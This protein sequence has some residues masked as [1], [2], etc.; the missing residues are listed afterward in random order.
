MAKARLA[1]MTVQNLQFIFKKITRTRFLKE[2]YY[3]FIKSRPYRWYK[4]GWENLCNPW[5]KNPRLK[6]EFCIFMPGLPM[7]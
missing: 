6:I 1:G 2:I 3:G 7:S 4:K 5:N